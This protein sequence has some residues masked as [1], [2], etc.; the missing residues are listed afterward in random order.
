MQ[1]FTLTLLFSLLALALASAASN[2][3]HHGNKQLRR[4]QLLKDQ[5]VSLKVNLTEHNVQV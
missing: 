5:Q 4:R 3:N 2:E 1:L